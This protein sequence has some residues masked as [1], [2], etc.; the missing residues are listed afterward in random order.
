MRSKNQVPGL[1]PS[2]LEDARITASSN[3]GAHLLIFRGRE[4]QEEA[5]IIAKVVP[6]FRVRWIERTLLTLIPHSMDQFFGTIN[7]FLSEEIEWIN[8]VKPHD[9]S[10][11]LL[12][13]ECAFSAAADVRHLWTAAAE[14]GIERIRLAARARERFKLRHW[15]PQ[16]NRS[17][18]WI[19]GDDRVFDHRGA[20]HGVAPFPRAW[21]LSYQAAPGFHFDVTARVSRA[22]HVQAFDGRRQAVSQPRHINIDP[23]GHVRI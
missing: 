12:L 21:K 14:A 11:C 22:F 1:A 3:G 20:R 15:L 6:Y 18:R 8:T 23:H 16:K 5:L 9:E 7:E 10:C 13:P 2:Q 19:D 4:R 17:R